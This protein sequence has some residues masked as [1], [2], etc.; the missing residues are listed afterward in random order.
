MSDTSESVVLS[1]VQLIAMRYGG[2]GIF[3]LQPKKL[4]YAFNDPNIIYHDD[5]DDDDDIENTMN[6]ESVGFS[7]QLF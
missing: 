2:D 5:D 6:A 1:G 3:G 4:I 7:P